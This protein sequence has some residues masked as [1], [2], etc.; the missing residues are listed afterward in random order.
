M[1]AHLLFWINCNTVFINKLLCI[2]NIFSL[3][4]Q[5]EAFIAQEKRKEI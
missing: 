5:K 2:I 3:V 4:G 1:L